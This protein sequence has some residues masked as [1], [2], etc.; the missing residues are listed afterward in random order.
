MAPLVR[1]PDDLD[2]LSK[3]ELIA[4]VRAQAATIATLMKRVEALEE[5]LRTNSQNSSKP[6]STDP[7][8]TPPK[9]KKPTRTRGRRPGGQPGHPGHHRPL[10]PTADVDQV[11]PHTPKRCGRCQS[12]R[13]QRT[14]AAPGRKQVW[15]IPPT[16]P[17]VTEHQTFEAACLDC[18]HTTRAVLPDA[19]PRGDFGPRAIAIGAYL[20][21]VLHNGR[22]GAQDALQEL[23]GLE[24][25]LGTVSANEGVVSAAL[26]EPYREAHAEAQA[27]PVAH[28]DETG[29]RQDRGKAWL[30]VMATAAV[31]VF[32][33]HVS[34]GRDAAT[35]LL[36]AFKGILVTDRWA[37]Y[38]R[39]AVWMRQ[40]CWA[41]LLRDFTKISE[42]KG[43]AAIGR[44]L[45]RET[46]A[47]FHAWHQV[48]D[49][50][51]TR[52]AFITF[53]T[54]LRARVEALLRRGE[55][56]R[57]AGTRGMC[58]EI[59]RLAPA[60]WTFVA[61]EGVEPTNNTGERAI[62]NGVIWRK[63]SFG[64]HSELG[65][66]F[67]ERMLT[68]RATLR[69]QGRSVLEFLTRTVEAHQHDEPAPSLL[70]AAH[71]TDKQSLAA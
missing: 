10:V 62:R 27:A 51:M 64:S 41:H 47:M 3:R 54:P 39:W 69:Q 58:R 31:T 11:V 48:R 6:P 24:M 63:I 9:P 66:R 53:M 7:P 56:C 16:T 57:H 40:L 65:G 2:A 67:V 38:D 13:V 21:G 15:E 36:G 50:T 42:R 29:W 23:F 70:P 22:R 18:G 12:R 43:S 8:A 19:V 44:A 71:T 25:S 52:A 20:T 1:V 28:A 60:L 26:A 5:Q 55:R 68:V 49:G 32:L 17:H 4:L 61:T 35:T 34:R 37:V 45:L 33:V 14:D 30:W 46:R 59:L